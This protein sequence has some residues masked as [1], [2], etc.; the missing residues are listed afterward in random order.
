[1]RIYLNAQ[2]AS[3]NHRERLISVGMT[4]EA[5]EFYRIVGD[6]NA[7]EHA[8]RDAWMREH[9]LSRLP[10]LEEGRDWH[11][12]EDHPDVNSVMREEQLVDDVLDFVDAHMGPELWGWQSSFAYVTIRHLFGKLTDRPNG[13]PGWCGELASKWAEAGKPELPTRGDNG[14]H[15]LEQAQWARDVDG[16]LTQLLG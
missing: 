3:G 15:A 14:N 12:D 8:R 16:I 13:F 4:S 11:W 7:V 5:G 2:F 9:V 6:N 10:Y 1:M